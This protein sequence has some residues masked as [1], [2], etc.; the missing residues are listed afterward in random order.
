MPSSRITVGC[1][2]RPAQE[3]V[4]AW[5]EELDVMAASLRACVEAEPEAVQSWSVAFEYELPLE[6]GRRPDVVVLAGAAVVVLEFK[7]KALPSPADVDQVNA[8]ARDLADY[9]G[10]CRIVPVQP[11]LVLQG[12]APGFAREYHGVWL[13]SPETVARYLFA[14]AV[15]GSIDLGDW[16]NA[17][18]SPL[19][20]LVEAA[21]RIF[22]H[23]PLPH[24]WRAI[25]VGIPDTVELLGQQEPRPIPRAGR[26]HRADGARASSLR[27]GPAP[28]RGLTPV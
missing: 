24:V 14:G 17:P 10:G 8:Y 2:E 1:G 3:Q 15:D 12:A 13:T 9:H 20:T 23:E 5:S 11:V 27:R 16:L 26:G 4:N 7:S 19:P 18:Y 21:R 25:S 28:R 6:G 22:R